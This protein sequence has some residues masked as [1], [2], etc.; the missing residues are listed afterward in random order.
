MQEFRE[1][2]GYRV[3]GLGF[4]GVDVRPPGLHVLA[5]SDRPLNVFE[6]SV[7]MFPLLTGQEPTFKKALDWFQFAY[8]ADRAGA[9]VVPASRVLAQSVVAEGGELFPA[10]LAHLRRQYLE[11]Y[12]PVVAMGWAPERREIQIGERKGLSGGTGVHSSIKLV[13]Y[14]GRF[15]NIS[16]AGINKPSPNLTTVY[17]DTPI[18]GP[19]LEPL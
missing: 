7:G 19:A 5:S 4:P 2:G 15:T 14:A 6:A 8:T 1:V 12:G 3:C 16:L 10:L 13:T 17:L 9:Y 11:M 18:V